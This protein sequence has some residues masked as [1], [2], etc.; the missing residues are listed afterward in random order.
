MAR[1][2]PWILGGLVVGSAFAL[3]ITKVEDSDA[4]AHLAL[5]REMVKLRG[6][7]QHEPFTFP[8]AG[9][10]YY[11][12]EWLFDVVLYLAYAGADLAGVILLKSAI[13]ATA[14]WVLWKDASLPDQ[15]AADRPLS[16]AVAAAVIL[17]V[18]LMIRHRFAERPD[19]ILMLFLAF[20]VYALD[21]Y[22]HGGRRF[23]YALPAVQVLWVNVH[24]S[25]VV[26]AGPFAAVLGGGLLL[27][28]IGRW[29]GVE[30]PGTPSAA[31]LKTVALVFAGVA[32][33]SLLNPYGSDAVT[34]PFRLAASPWFTQE[35]LELQPPTFSSHPGA[36]ILVALLSV[37]FVLLARRLPLVSLLVAAPFVYLG[38][39]AVRF[40][41]LLGIACG[42]ILA[43]NLSAIAG[44]LKPAWARLALGVALA[45][46]TGGV[47]AT[48]LT[49]ASVESLAD[50][51]KAAGIGMD[52]R[53]VPEGALRYL[54]RI[55]LTGRIFNTFHWGGYLTWRDFPRRAPIIDGRGY[56]PPGLVEEIHFARI[57]PQHLDRLQTTYGFDVALVDYPV[58]AGENIEEALP[59]VDIALASPQWALVY[60]DDV[61]LVYL[62][63]ADHLAPIIARDEYR[64]VKPANSLVFLRRALADR[65]ALPAVE[66]ELRRNIAETGS[67]AGYAL[68]GAAELTVGAYDQA[69]QMF[70][71]VRSER[72]RLDTYQGLAV[73]HWAKGDVGA[74]VVFYRKLLHLTQDPTVLYQMGRALLETGNHREAIAHLERARA[75]APGMVAVY[76][77]LLEAYRRAGTV[78]ER[79]QELAAGYA[80]AVRLQEADEHTRRGR[81]LLGAGRLAEGVAELK[82]SLHLEPQSAR[83]H[84]DLG[85]AYLSLGQLD[86]A[87]AEQRAAIGLDPKLAS[88]QYG[89]ALID[90]RRGDQAAARRHLEQFVRLQPRSYLAWR[91]REEL[92]RLPR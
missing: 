25:A 14:A 10:P 19:M 8:S 49:V 90:Q 70:E 12:T 39:S 58:Y 74:A 9:M 2:L 84:S 17:G 50:P 6:F 56:V 69:I 63:R 80:N 7:P 78:V 41:F 68:L 60:W 85:F 82:A 52:E 44:R 46:T 20:T 47:A 53:F 79:E 5:G 64:I 87:V 83:V 15:R 89:L 81:Q 86:D 37:T 62:R 40:V 26:S 92:S 43:R 59:G 55:G 28:W 33:A 77:A 24:P 88:A 29:R 31:Q 91:V 48:A 3:G 34:L 1:I 42:P 30:P 4:W 36:L 45:G 22:L 35:I 51:R 73:A 21:A 76:P 16:L 65:G 11:N 13:V 32:V 27:R 72:A 67:S 38:L 57:Y 23:L 54:D 71:H 66:T 75:A 18:L 61:A